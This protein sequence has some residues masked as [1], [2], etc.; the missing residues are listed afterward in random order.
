MLHALIVAAGL[1][2]PPTP[3]TYVTDIANAL[4]AA[5]TTRIDNELRSYEAAT[6]HHV[7]VY[8]GES[9]GDTPLEDWTINAA[10]HWKVGRKRKDDGAILFVFMQDRKLRIEV[11]YGLESA[12]TDADASRIIRD[13]IV[14][15][16]RAGDVDGA[17]QSGI[18][19]M[20]VT[21]T[22]SFANQLGHAVTRVQQQP[23]PD[24][25]ILIPFLFIFISLAIVIL[26]NAAS[27]RAGNRWYGSGPFAGGGSFQSGGSSFGGSGGGSFGGSFGGG[28]ASGGW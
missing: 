7:I 22:P 21:I 13:N 24:W 15:R 2:A 18:D 1:A 3:T 10:E 23:P 9:T 16:M 4:S 19:Q 6:G 25:V 12:L 26:A 20:L 14:P 11:G 27:R 28:G 17:I 8:I 5:A